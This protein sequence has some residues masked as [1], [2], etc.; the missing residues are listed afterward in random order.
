[1]LWHF[2][3]MSR[4][5]PPGLADDEDARADLFR[6]AM[7]QF[8]EL[9][10]AAAG[11]GPASSPLLVYYALNQAGRAVLAVREQDDAGV[12]A[13]AEG[14]GLTINR[15]SVGHDLLTVTIKPKGASIGHFQR[16]ARATGSPV[17]QDL[18]AV[19][20][21]ALLASLPELADS[22]GDDRWPATGG[23]Y[24][25]MDMVPRR[26]MASVMDASLFLKGWARVAVLSDV[27]QGPKDVGA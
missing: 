3:R 13:K 27:V 26:G 15:G 9:M 17:L 23:V 18:G 25:L 20:L 24:P 16:V 5:K 7:Q 21:G 19:T 2:L 1:M 12:F 22:W 4:W 10:R 6:T 14:H 8:K 11:T